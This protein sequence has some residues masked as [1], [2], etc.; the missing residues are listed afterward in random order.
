MSA[1]MMPFKAK[2]LHATVTI[3]IASIEADS[4]L[5][6]TYDLEQMKAKYKED[7]EADFAG[8]CDENDVDCEN[9]QATIYVEGD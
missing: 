7:L 5:F 1:P 4:Q 3:K 9:V 6:Q 2:K 8:L